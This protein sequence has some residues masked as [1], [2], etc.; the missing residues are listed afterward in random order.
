MSKFA[1]SM[2]ILSGLLI[3]VVCYLSLSRYYTHGESYKGPLS[4]HFDGKKFYNPPPYAKRSALDTFR[5][6]LTRDRKKW[7][8]HVENKPHPPLTGV[9]S[10]DE[11]KVTF[12]NHSSFLLQMQN[13]N[14]LTDPVWSYRVSPFSWLGPARV[15]EPGINFAELPKINIVLISHNHYDH[16]DLNTLRRLNECFHPLFIVPL[17]NKK[18][19]EDRGIQNVIELDWW[20][21]YSVDNAIITFLPSQH[22]SARWLNDRFSTLW[23]GYGIF[24]HNKKI[25]FAGDSGSSSNFALIRQQWGVPDLSFLPIGAYEPEWFMRRNHLNPEEAVKSHLELQSR[26]SIGIHYGTFQLSDEGMDDPANALVK[27]VGKYHLQ[28][29]QIT[30]LDVGETRSYH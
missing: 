5:W 22:W 27:A 16:M 9:S 17:G 19:L 10:P 18:Y 23:G 13:L 28:E 26:Q 25:Y 7:P 24:Y 4:N 6:W 11:L 15:R 21:T 1:F 2:L 8:V 29:G 30:L 3:I 12:I 14:I 20:Q